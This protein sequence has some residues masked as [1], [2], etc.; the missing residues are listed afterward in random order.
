M[1]RKGR[2]SPAEGS[3]PA[4]ARMDLKQDA[5]AGHGA[6]GYRPGPRIFSPSPNGLRLSG[7]RSGAERVR[8]S[9]GFGELLMFA[10]FIS[11]FQIELSQVLGG[12]MLR[13]P[14]AN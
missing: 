5:G 3:L 7:E 11:R 13:P 1:S 14:V 8:C 2:A 10:F 12:R 9:R 4:P 6:A